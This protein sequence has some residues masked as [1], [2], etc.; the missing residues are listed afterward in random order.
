MA[1]PPGILTLSLMKVSCPLS[2]SVKWDSGTCLLG[3]GVMGKEISSLNSSRADP[4]PREFRPLLRWE[5]WNF[6][7]SPEEWR[8]PALCLDN[9]AASTELV[10]FLFCSQLE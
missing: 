6:S 3:L 7:P 4:G 5:E 8:T 1:D 9:Q 2:L 10:S